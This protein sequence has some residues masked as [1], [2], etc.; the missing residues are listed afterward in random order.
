[1]H[2]ILNALESTNDKWIVDLLYAF[3][4]GDLARFDALKPAWSQQADLKAAEVRMRQ[5]IC[6]LCLMEMSFTRPATNKQL[7]FDEIAV[8]TQLPKAEV[9]LLVMRALS[10]GLVKGSIDQIDRNVFVSWV[11][12]RV[13]D[14]EQ[15]KMMR[16][17]LDAW[18][19]DV[20]RMVGQIQTNMHEIL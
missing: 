12:P 9:E 16:V 11:Q 17:R 14:L 18:S 4:K 10:L 13:L 8:R 3:N 1:M 15:I 6:L 5:K 20:N 19:I 7:A 2:P